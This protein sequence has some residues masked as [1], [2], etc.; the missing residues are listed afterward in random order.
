MFS[1][2]P[3]HSCVLHQ[4]SLEG[5]LRIMSHIFWNADPCSGLVKKS[6]SMFSLGQYVTLTSPFCILSVKKKYLT[7]RCHV[8][9]PLDNLPFSDNRILLLLSWYIVV[10]DTW[11]PCAAR[12]C[13][14]HSICPIATS[15]TTSSASVEL[16]CIQLLFAWCHVC[17]AFANQH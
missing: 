11:I 16:F 9:F 15:I 4:F 13:L 17:T 10:V 7:L 3:T 12:K 8:L 1:L 6:A 5:R 14:V 2:L